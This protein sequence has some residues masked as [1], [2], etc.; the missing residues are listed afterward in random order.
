MDPIWERRRHERGGWGRWDCAGRWAERAP[1]LAQ[2][3][4]DA[5]PRFVT[6]RVIALAATVVKADVALVGAKGQ[7]VPL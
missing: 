4:L 2:A 1:V 7:A 5:D 6:V 3:V